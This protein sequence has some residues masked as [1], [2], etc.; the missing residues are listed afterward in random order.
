MSIVFIR[1][2]IL[3]IIVIFSVRLMGKRQIG[4]LQPSELV[5]TILVSNIA[6]LP[7]EDLNIPLSMGIL[8]ILS[9]VCFE[10]L[11]SWGTLRSKRLRHI[12]SGSPKVIIKDGVLDQKVMKDLR[13]SVDDLMTALRGSSIFDISDVQF[14][15]VETN[16]SVSV[17]EKYSRRNVINQDMKLKGESIDPPMIIISDGKIIKQSLEE[18]GLTNKW[19]TDLLNKKHLAETDVFMLTADKSG[20]YTLIKKG[21]SNGKN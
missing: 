1:A 5:I 21:D 6:T 15:V 20:N 10:V 12:V 7:L 3:Y 17:Y 16:G 4:E 13:F 19:V 11:M 18:S 2:I 8:P 14:A 9:L